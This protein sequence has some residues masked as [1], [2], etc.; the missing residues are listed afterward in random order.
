LRWRIIA[1]QAAFSTDISPGVLSN[2]YSPEK[3]DVAAP[4]STG[5]KGSE[6]VYVGAKQSVGGKK[7][8]KLRRACN[9]YH[10]S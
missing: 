9:S 6:D 3:N 8:E 7:E 10:R 2:W 1:E 5:Y 4:L